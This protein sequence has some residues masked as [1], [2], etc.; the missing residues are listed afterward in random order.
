MVEE[1]KYW[2]EKDCDKVNNNNNNNKNNNNTRNTFE[3]C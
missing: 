3:K 1:E 2:G